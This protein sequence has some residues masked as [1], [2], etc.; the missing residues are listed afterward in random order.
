M[1]IRRRKPKVDNVYHPLW[2]IQISESTVYGISSISEHYNRRMDE[3][4]A[5]IQGVRKIVDDVVVFDKDEQQHVEHVRE[6]LCRCG[7]E[8]L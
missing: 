3:A 2:P 8:F 5:V 4:F 1:P 7:E 6:I